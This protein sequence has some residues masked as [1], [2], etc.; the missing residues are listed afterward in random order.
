MVSGSLQE[1]TDDRLV[2]KA[3]LDLSAE[4]WLL[5]RK[6]FRNSEKSVQVN[7]TLLTIGNGY[8]NIRGSLEELPPG[9]A[10][11]MYVG[12]IYDKSEADV[13]E[14]VKCPM[15]TDVSV[16]SD[17][18]KFCMTTCKVLSHEQIL[19]MK[20][21]VLHR[22]TTL[23]NPAG[24]IVRLETARLVFMHDVHLGYMMV[25][26]TPINFSGPIRVLSGLNGEVCNRGFFPRE[27]LKHLQLERIERGRALMYIEMKTRE[28]GI[29]IAEAASWKL[30]SPFMQSFA[31][32]P[33]IYGEK[34]TSEISLEARQGE[35]YVFEKLVVVA[36]SREFV[37][38]EMFKGTICKLKSFVRTGVV[39][40]IT[41]HLKAWNEKWKQADIVLI[42]DE[43]AQHAVRFNVY[44]LLI[45]APSRP[46]GIGAKFLSSEGYLGHVFWD[47]EIFILPFYVYN[48]PDVARNMLLYRY[49]TLD[50]AKKNALKMGCKGAKYAWESATTGEDVTPRFASK[51]ERTI[52]LIYTGTEE[53]HIVSDVIYGVEKY[54]RVTGDDSFLVDYGFE[55]VFLTARFWASR[56]VEE[57][58]HYEIRC[59]IGPDE[60]HEH[61]NNNAYTNFMVKWHLG[62]AVLLFKYM[63]RSYSGILDDLV[64]KIGLEREEVDVWLAISRKL[65]LTY[66]PQTRLFEQ[67]DGYFSLKDYLV[68][69]FDRKGHP[70][71]PEGI[72]YSNI[73]STRLIKQADVLIMMMLFPHSFSDEDKRANFDFYEKRTAHASSL[74]HC[75]HAM[76]GLSVGM[77][78]RAYHYF[79]KTALFDLENL[80]ENTA[81]GIHAA[82]VGGTWQTVISGFGGFSIKSDRMVLKPWLPKKWESLSF[83]VQW[84]ARTV[85][86]TIFHDRVALLVISDE[87]LLLPVTL[88]EKTW[89][90]MTNK[91]YELPYCVVKR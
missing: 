80:H 3:L 43:K 2:V 58:D 83:C 54:F 48:F 47:T 69:K 56:V 34:F 31:W 36:T 78:T 62:L 87:K 10:G 64:A 19:D 63:G 7:E 8:L 30:V 67:F 73:Q 42:G 86:I 20:K 79:M 37:A 81:L 88:Y 76:M 72:D 52:R 14:L 29:R 17:G 70:V 32:E 28:R 21:G 16:W 4:E 13:E 49:N 59:V 57:G 40:E 33:R 77:R 39:P 65:R 23:V 6:G 60:F 61:V 71:L 35:S 1:A 85:E 53:D 26:V 24:Q 12:G 74:S 5:R 41:A 22:S 9:N 46:A 75:I 55:M 18:C 82:A 90:I 68:E 11:G 15:W 27:K 84:R 89:K 66:D 44:Q 91:R 38:E 45:N 25:T 51:L 50:G